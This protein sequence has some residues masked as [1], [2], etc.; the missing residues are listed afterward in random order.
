MFSVDQAVLVALG[1][2][3]GKLVDGALKWRAA[4]DASRKIGAEAQAAEGAEARKDLKFTIETMK[5]QIAQLSSDVLQ[6]RAETAKIHLENLRLSGENALLTQTIATMRAEIEA[7]NDAIAELTETVRAQGVQLRETLDLLKER[8]G[9]IN[10]TDL[11]LSP[12]LTPIEPV[13]P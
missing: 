13:K 5:E 2:L 7:K 11:T 9:A 10:V 6:A 4:N 1:A 3:A 8:A 12:S